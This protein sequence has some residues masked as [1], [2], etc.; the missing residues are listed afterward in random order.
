MYFINL[1]KHRLGDVNFEALDEETRKRVA[2][3]KKVCVFVVFLRGLI[4]IYDIPYLLHG[5]TYKNDEKGSSF[6]IHPDTDFEKGLWR[7][8][9]FINWYQ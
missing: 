3:S 9:S 7:L 4:R 5:G 8:V 1:V 2:T 6:D